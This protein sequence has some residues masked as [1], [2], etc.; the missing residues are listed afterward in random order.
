ML[1]FVFFCENA[2]V[3]AANK[4]ISVELADEDEAGPV[5][6]ISFGFA[7]EVIGA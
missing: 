3:A 6:D 7:V 1:Q 4:E 5:E 2:S